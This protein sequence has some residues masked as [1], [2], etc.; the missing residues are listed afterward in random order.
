[1]TSQRYEREIGGYFEL[2]LN[3]GSEYH[4]TALRLNS[5]RNALRYIL[6]QKNFKK[7]YL[8]FYICDSVVD[9]VR[10]E[11]V[12]F[13]FY[14][15]TAQ[16]EPRIKAPM[17]GD[18]AILL[19][20]YFGVMD[21]LSERFTQKWQTVIIDNCQA[22]FAKPLP[23]IPTFY[24]P[25]KFLG[26]ADGAYLYIDAPADADLP[27]DIS[28]ARYRH[29]LIRHD[30]S[31][32]D[33]YLHYRHTEK[34]LAET[35]IQ[36]MSILTRRILQSID[37]DP[38]K[39]IR[40]QNFTFLHECLG[41]HN[42]FPLELSKINIPMVYPFLSPEP[43]LRDYLIQ[44]RIFVAQYWKEVLQ[45]IKWGTFE[46]QLASDLIPLPIDQRWNGKDMERVAEI[47]ERF[48]SRQRRTV[49]ISVSGNVSNLQGG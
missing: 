41:K 46:Y 34:L 5:G 22:F 36:R 21:Q 42:L 16:F 15:L 31:A 1:M 12:E 14:A 40:K 19:I 10:Q 6:R 35:P 48:L 7:I 13:R 38:I 47:V 30:R 28:H 45:R 20:N 9:A 18:T 27:V 24:S 8:P 11:G 43:G 2:E 25:R 29:L 3:S 17:S 37:Y 39:R 32:G 4:T 23:G 49:P 33:G 44:H 26:V